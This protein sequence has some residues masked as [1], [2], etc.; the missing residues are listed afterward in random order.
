METVEVVLQSILVKKTVFLHIAVISAIIGDS[1]SGKSTL[2]KMIG[3]LES[4]SGWEIW[5]DNVNIVTLI[6]DKLICY[7]KSVIY[8][9]QNNFGGWTNRKQ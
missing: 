1:G 7:C 9:T 2:L 5:L 6:G 8:A 4:Q 3:G